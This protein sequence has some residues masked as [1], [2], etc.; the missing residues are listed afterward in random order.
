MFFTIHCNPSLAYIAVRDLQCSQ[1][2]ARVYSHSHW[3]AVFCTTIGSRVLA[4]ERWQTFE[5]YGKNT[6][7][8]ERP[9]HNLIDDVVREEVGLRKTFFIRKSL[10]LK[11]K[12][13][14]CFR[15]CCSVTLYIIFDFRRKN[16]L[17][18]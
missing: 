15:P 18:F 14:H 1:R 2:K 8:N 4:R 13:R 12:C 11:I 17:D 5:N 6:I 10:G 3:L 9:V 16:S 7:F